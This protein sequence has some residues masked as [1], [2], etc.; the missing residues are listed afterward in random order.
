[1][2]LLYTDNLARGPHRRDVQVLPLTVFL[3]G[4]LGCKFMTLILPPRHMNAYIA[5][6]DIVYNIASTFL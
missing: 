3:E 5:T 1:M 4:K 6:N 2:Y